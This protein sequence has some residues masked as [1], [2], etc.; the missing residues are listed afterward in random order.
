MY[1]PP[2]FDPQR[3]ARA[4]AGSHRATIRMEVWSG[5]QQ[6]TER[7][8]LLTGT[9]TEEWATGIRWSLECTVPPTRA[10]LRWLDMPNLEL[11]PYRGVRLSPSLTWEAPLGRYPLLPPELTRPQA[12]ISISVS[13]YYQWVSTAKFPG[14]VMSYPGKVTDSIAR[15]LAEAGLPGTDIRTGKQNTAGAV[16]IDQQRDEWVASAAKSISC[17]VYLDRNGRPVITDAVRLGTPTSQALIGPGKTAVG[18]KRTPD[19]SRVY[20]VVYASSSASDVELP[21]ERAAITLPSHPAHPTRLGSPSRPNYRVY[22]YS[23]PLLRTTPQIQAAAKSILQRVSSMAE[24]YSYVC[25]PDPFRSASDTLLGAT[26]DGGSQTVQIQSVGHPLTLEEDQPITGVS[27]RVD[28]DL[29]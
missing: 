3:W 7:A 22:L 27:T 15:V 13:D 9:A 2:G 17:E 26:V 1:Q 19:W 8:P 24:Q 20:N 11:R 18:V 23:S 12:P 4:V 21:A 10:W 6:L 28:D 5:N 16:L 25:L 14:P 29:S